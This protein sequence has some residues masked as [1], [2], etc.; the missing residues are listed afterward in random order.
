[1]KHYPHVPHMRL[2]HLHKEEQRVQSKHGGHPPD[3]VRRRQEVR[4]PHGRGHVRDDITR[5]E[6]EDPLV[7]GR[8]HWQSKAG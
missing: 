7:E 4:K 2:H 5:E 1:M 3:A 8:A 6:Q